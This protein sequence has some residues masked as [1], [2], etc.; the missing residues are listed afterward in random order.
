MQ[1]VACAPVGG[2]FQVIR[3]SE[4]GRPGQME[5]ERWRLKQMRDERL[6]LFGTD[7]FFRQLSLEFSQGARTSLAYTRCPSMAEARL[8]ASLSHPV[9]RFVVDSNTGLASAVVMQITQEWTKGDKGDS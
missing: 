1:I 4:P 3:S 7:R 9:V 6:A 2:R 8:C 5:M